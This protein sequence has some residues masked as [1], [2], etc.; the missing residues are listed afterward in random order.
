[1]TTRTLPIVFTAPVLL[2]LLVVQATIRPSSAQGPRALVIEAR[3]L[4]YDANFRND[5]TGL[6]SAIA[7]LQPLVSDADVGAYA[8]YYLSWTYWALAA[9]QVEAKDVPG[10]IASGTLSA[11]HAR[12]GLAVR[13]RDPEF[14]TALVNGLIVV[15]VLDKAQFQA[16][17]AEI[18]PVRKKALEL[19]A[20]NPRVVMMDAGMLFNN[21]PSVGGGQDKGLARWKEALTLFEV[22][23]KMTA[24]D[25]IAPRWGHALAH[26]WLASMYLALTPPQKENAR[27]AAE[28][29]LR[30]RPDFWWVRERVLPRLRE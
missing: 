29:S 28:T 14:L 1:M 8:N 17:A 16:A 21:P 6:R 19:G 30:M 3:N 2:S 5:Q 25:P 20:A 24:A 23:S 27:I 4:A 26:G 12:R 10:A 22:E 11:E 7:A 9:S 18:R 13:E 15:A